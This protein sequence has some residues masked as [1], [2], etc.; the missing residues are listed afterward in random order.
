MDEEA[1]LDDIVDGVCGFFIL[2]D[3]VQYG[4]GTI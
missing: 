2:S 4:M 1:Y 3:L